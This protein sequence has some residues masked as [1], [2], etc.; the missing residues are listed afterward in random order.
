MFSLVGEIKIKKFKIKKKE[1]K[2]KIACGL[3]LRQSDGLPITVGGK[4]T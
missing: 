2:E 1:K 4:P 3:R